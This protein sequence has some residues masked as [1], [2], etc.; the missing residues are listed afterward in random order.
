MEKFYY[1]DMAAIGVDA[2][3]IYAPATEYIP[4]IISQ[5]ERL[6]KKG[7]AYETMGSVYFDVRKFDEYGRLSG[8]KISEL[9]EGVRNE[10]EPGKKYFADFAVWKEAKTGE[11]SWPS[12]WG[13]GRP[14]WHIEDTAITEKHFGPRYHLHGGGRDLIFPHH[15][16]EIAQMEAVSGLKPLA[17]IWIHTGLLQVQGE[18]MAKS[19]GNFITIRDFLK[20]HSKETLRYLVLASHYRTP[21]DFSPK[22]VE[23][24][25]AS[26]Q[27]ISDFIGRLQ[28][29]TETASSFLVADFINSFW[30]E[31]A[32]DFNT[33]QAL[34]VL[35][36]L[37]KETNKLMD[38]HSLLHTDAKK[39]IDFINEVN[40]IWGIL[41]KEE[42]IPA[43]I[44]ALA[45]ERDRARTSGDFNKADE[46]RAQIKNQGWDI[47]DT[48]TG[49][50]INKMSKA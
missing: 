16:A 6:I 26:I 8:Q 5:V 14:G 21:L 32:D 9:K 34:A 46:L 2:V 12:P 49:P 39:I 29:V 7:F 20:K 47:D 35:F 40:D 11:P 36:E 10:V 15:E 37:I 42:K 33:P 41:A 4:E 24:A 19:V 23:M 50:R 28:T 3:S 31:L 27:R 17:Q 38:T 22:L 48:S 1:E 13:E 30:K 45:Q 18:K 44:M 43:E 25:Q